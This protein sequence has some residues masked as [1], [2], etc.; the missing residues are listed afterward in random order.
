MNQMKTLAIGGWFL[1]WAL[2]GD[3][4]LHLPRSTFWPPEMLPT[5]LEGCM[6]PPHLSLLQ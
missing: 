4:V 3:S 1:V 2:Q 5:S 6:C